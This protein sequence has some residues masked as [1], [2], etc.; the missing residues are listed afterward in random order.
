MNEEDAQER[1][2]N[3]ETHFMIITLVSIGVWTIFRIFHLITMYKW[4][5][6]L[7]NGGMDAG[8]NIHT[9]ASLPSAATSIQRE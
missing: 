4:L 5:E 1:N 6:E 7:Q 8:E 9:K 2:A 3:F